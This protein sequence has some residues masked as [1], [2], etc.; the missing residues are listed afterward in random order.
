MTRTI[1]EQDL[2]TWNYLHEELD[3]IT[4]DGTKDAN[5]PRGIELLSELC[6]LKATILNEVVG[7][8]ESQ[9]D[10]MFPRQVSAKCYS[11]LTDKNN[12]DR[13]TEKAK[14]FKEYLKLKGVAN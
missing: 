1:T 13:M 10:Q 11:A 7:L 14:E 5:S 3:V 4:E 9:I 8:D 2:E 6:Q 12:E